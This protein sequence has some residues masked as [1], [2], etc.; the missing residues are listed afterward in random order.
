[1]HLQQW[2]KTLCPGEGTPTPGRWEGQ[3]AAVLT[4]RDGRLIE[5]D[6]VHH[7]PDLPVL[8]HR[9]ARHLAEVHHP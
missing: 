8:Q 3:N 1:M 9:I 4:L 2:A 5:F 7:R 6:V